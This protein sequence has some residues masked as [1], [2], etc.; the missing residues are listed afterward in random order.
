M[1]GDPELGPEGIMAALAADEKNG[2]IIIDNVHLAVAD[3]NVRELDEHL[4]EIIRRF[5]HVF[6]IVV[7]RVLRPIETL[8]A[9]A[10]PTTIVGPRELALDSQ[11]LL[12]LATGL[13]VRMSR[14]RAVSLTDGV[15][16]WPA[17]LRVSLNHASL[18]EEEDRKSTRLNSS[19][20][21]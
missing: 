21:A 11:R 14:N 2:L 20:V 15:A 18:T 8:G 4:I 10:L 19:H 13:G 7:G 6:F 12:A 5:S 16:G 3:G 1:F 9:M 17:L